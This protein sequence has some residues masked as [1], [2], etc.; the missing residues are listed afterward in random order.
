MVTGR[1][2]VLAGLAVLGLAPSLPAR[3]HRSHTSQTT[4]GWNPRTAELEVVHR[5]HA[6]DAE[7]ALGRLPGITT[8]DLA[9]P[10][11]QARL[12]LYVEQ[13]FALAGADG[14]PLALTLVGAELEGMEVYVYQTS[15]MAAAPTALSVR[16]TVLHDSFPDQANRIS[17]VFPRPPGGDL[18]RTATLRPGDGW[19][20]LAP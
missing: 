9:K 7:V 17:V 3:A 18:V 15:P 10:A 16:M 1:R 5:L 6:H 2:G 12:A 8:P 11:H 13:H 20:R 4:I 14:T 19:T